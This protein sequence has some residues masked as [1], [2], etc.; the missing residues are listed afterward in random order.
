MKRLAEDTQL[1]QI[2][3]IDG[4]TL[5]FEARTAV[6]E[7]Y[8]AFCLK[9]RVGQINSLEELPPETAERLRNK[10]DASPKEPAGETLN[11]T[12]SSEGNRSSTK[13]AATPNSPL[14][15]P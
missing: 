8:D 13:Q 4:D 3:H 15:Q 5:R 2:I 1:Y 7:L 9:K 11:Q 14:K 6:G 10:G 12:G